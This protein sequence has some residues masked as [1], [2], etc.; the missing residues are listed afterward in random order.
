MS[1][2]DTNLQQFVRWDSSVECLG[3]FVAASHLAANRFTHWH[4]SHFYLDFFLTKFCIIVLCSIC[5]VGQEVVQAHTS[6]SR[7]TCVS[8]LC[9]ARHKH[10]NLLGKLVQV[11]LSSY[12]CPP[13]NAHLFFSLCLSLLLQSM[14][15]VEKWNIFS[16]G[17]NFRVQKKTKNEGSF[18]GEQKKKRR[19]G[20]KQVVNLTWH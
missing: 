11:P 15:E 10:W 6:A 19:L 14:S 3:L 2:N 12:T 1:S 16:Q 18:L 20:T 8:R 4:I 13:P 7:N 9:T 17:D 5:L